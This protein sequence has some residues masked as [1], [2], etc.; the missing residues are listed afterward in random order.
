MTARGALV[1]PVVGRLGVRGVRA[2]EAGRA[3]LRVKG[4]LLVR[5]LRPLRRQ[6]A[7]AGTAC[8]E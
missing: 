5:A 1:R 4:A 8:L 7:R 6:L 3:R 2:P